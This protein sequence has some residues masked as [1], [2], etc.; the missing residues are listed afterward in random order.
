MV[1]YAF[2]RGQTDHFAAYLHEAFQS[3][4]NY[5]LSFRREVAEVAGVVPLVAVVQDKER[6]GRSAQVSVEDADTLGDDQSLL[7][8]RELFV[9]VDGDDHDGHAGNSFANA[10]YLFAG[11]GKTDQRRAFGDAVALDDAG[12]RR[13]DR[14][15]VEELLGRFLAAN[16]HQSYGLE[17]F[18]FPRPQDA[19][20]EGG[21]AAH[22]G[23]APLYRA[24]GQLAVGRGIGIVRYP[25]AADGGHQGGH[26]KTEGVEGRQEGIQ[27]VVRRDLGADEHAVDIVQKVSI[28]QGH[29][30]GHVLG[31]A[32]EEN[33][34]HV[35]LFL[36]LDAEALK[37][38][39]RLVILI[40]QR[41]QFQT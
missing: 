10:H 35:V 30:L 17:H 27:N 3:S 14:E 22:D 5:Q 15:E 33:D 19:F 16:A 9:L 1:Q 23:G 37:K 25:D 4:R 34:R 36:I 31:T 29:A 28:A 2:K 39:F 18:G 40:A 11:A 8:S 6:V 32:G 21:G 7:V 38:F 24:V 41:L 12:V 13:A 26:G 20:H